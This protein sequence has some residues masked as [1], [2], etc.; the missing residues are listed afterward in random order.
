MAIT[1]VEELTEATHI[2]RRKEEAYLQS[3]PL[4]GFIS[5][6][7]KICRIC[8]GFL[9]DKKGKRVLSFSR[10]KARPGESGE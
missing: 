10:G 1:A 4:Q 7:D 2:R 9:L 3:F 6:N 5:K 8:L